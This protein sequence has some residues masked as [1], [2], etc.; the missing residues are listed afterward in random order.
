MVLVMA[1]KLFVCSSGIPISFC[2]CFVEETIIFA[3]SSA[4]SILF[5]LKILSKSNSPQLTELQFKFF[6]L[7][8]VISGEVVISLMYL[9]EVGRVIP[10]KDKSFLEIT[11]SNGSMW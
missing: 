9:L 11:L 7:L 8:Y 3:K 5:I 6:T 1:I 10:Y 4:L 2:L